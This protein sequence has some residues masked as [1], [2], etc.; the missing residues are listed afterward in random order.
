MEFLSVLKEFHDVN[1][2]LRISSS[3][4]LYSSKIDAVRNTD[5]K[6]SDSE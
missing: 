5:E 4:I 2:V 1:S 6:S 3:K